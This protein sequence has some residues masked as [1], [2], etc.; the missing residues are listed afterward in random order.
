M[1][2]FDGF[3]CNNVM[4]IASK[5]YFN[6]RI[7]ENTYSFHLLGLERPLLLP[8]G[9]VIYL[10]PICLLLA[11]NIKMISTQ[12]TLKS[13]KASMYDSFFFPW[14]LISNVFLDL[15]QSILVISVI[16]P[17]SLYVGLSI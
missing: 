4:R 9:G 12:M 14:S 5:Y 2:K 17:S 7:I 10:Y 1:H 13:E 15:L 6:S 16:S 3:L 8:D 11:C